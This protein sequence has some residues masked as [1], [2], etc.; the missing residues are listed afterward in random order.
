MSDSDKDHES[1]VQLNANRGEIKTLVFGGEVVYDHPLP[2][3]RL[4]ETRLIYEKIQMMPDE[5]V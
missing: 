2:E 3:T 1:K 4:P 5:A